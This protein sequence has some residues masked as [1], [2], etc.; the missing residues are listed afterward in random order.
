MCTLIITTS[1]NKDKNGYNGNV[2]DHSLI[3][4]SVGVSEYQI[5]GQIHNACLDYLNNNVTTN[6]QTPR[7]TYASSITEKI[8]TWSNNNNISFTSADSAFNVNVIKS[9]MSDNLY[10]DAEATFAFILNSINDTIFAKDKDYIVELK[11]VFDD[12]KELSGEEKY[13][14]AQN[15]LQDIIT[16]YNEDNWGENQGEL[17]GGM[18]YIA[19]SSVN[20]WYSQISNPNFPPIYVNPPSQT[21]VAPVIAGLI[22][23]GLTVAQIDSAG[24]LYGWWKS[25]NSGEK[26]PKKRIKAGLSTAIDFSAAATAWFMVFS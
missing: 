2:L 24:Y 26:N 16:E 1:C 13:L 5:A 14:F 25:Y 18:L 10:G 23:A 20:Y 9:A 21:M 3:S 12:A 22:A 6:W 15:K 17:A 11:E 8:Y 4:M 7:D 19:Q